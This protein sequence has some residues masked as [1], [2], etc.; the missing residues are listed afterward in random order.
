LFTSIEAAADFN[1]L[2]LIPNTG[3]IFATSEDPKIQT[4]YIPVSIYMHLNLIVAISCK[5]C[6]CQCITWVSSNI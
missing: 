6:T 3:M 5:G 4:Y 2:C 1:V